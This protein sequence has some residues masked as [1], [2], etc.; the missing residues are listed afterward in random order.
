MHATPPPSVAVMGAGAVGC[1]FGG[2]LARAGVPVTLI[3]RPNHVEAIRQHGLFLD[4]RHF[5]GVVRVGA[6]TSARAVRSARFVLFC[7]KTLDNE[8]AAEALRPHL[9]PGALIVSLQ[10]GVDNVERLRAVLDVPVIPAVVYVGAEMAG[11]GR[12][13]HTARGD[14]V[15]GRLPAG[16]PVDHKELEGLASLFEGAGVPCRVSEAIEAELWRKLIINCAYNAVSALGQA[17]YGRI[18]ANPWT[19]EVLRKVAEEAAAVARAA[20]VP[21]DTPAMVE[22]V[23]RLADSMPAVRSSTA[24]DIARGKRTEIDS[25]NGYVARRGAEL[26]VPAPVN[27]TL[28]ALVKLREETAAESAGDPADSAPGRG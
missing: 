10:N 7:V 20:G 15:I 18:M 24:Q 25:F 4:S 9:A 17:R 2:M 6:D 21:L 11:P 1:Y 26:G 19:K 23:W 28:H 5:V 27:Q 16:G 3:G 13:K 14:L 22:A 12:V 8:S